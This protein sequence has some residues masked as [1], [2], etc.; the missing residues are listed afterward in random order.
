M[1]KFWV[2]LLD[3]LSDFHDN[4]FVLIQTPKRKKQGMIKQTCSTRKKYTIPHQELE[5]NPLFSKTTATAITPTDLLPNFQSSLL[6][7]HEWSKLGQC[8]WSFNFKMWFMHNFPLQ[9]PYIIWWAGN[10]NTQTHKVGVLFLIKHKI[11][12]TNFS[13]KCVA[14]KVE[15]YQLDLGS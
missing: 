5:P 9:H 15:N 13:G 11:L 8:D 1:K 7:P 2:L 4:F 14:V 6:F 3:I 12:T 10:E